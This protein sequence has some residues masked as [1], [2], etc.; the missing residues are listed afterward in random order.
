VVKQ[1]ILSSAYLN[2]CITDLAKKIVNGMYFYCDV[3]GGGTFI[4]TENPSNE[5]P[6]VSTNTSITV[7]EGGTGNITPVNLAATDDT[8]SGSELV[9]TV[10]TAPSNG[11]LFVDANHNDIYEIGEEKGVDATFTQQDIAVNKSIKPRVSN[12]Y[13]A[14][15]FVS[16]NLLFHK[17]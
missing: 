7:P 2:R 3:I 10:K 1:F 14:R 4:S 13:T 15:G 17:M 9:Y 8:D 16:D 11:L 12:P 5:A 6:E